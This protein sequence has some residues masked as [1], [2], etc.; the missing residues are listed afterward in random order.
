M[1]DWEWPCIFKSCPLELTIHHIY[2]GR[3]GQMWHICCDTLLYHQPVA[4][5]DSCPSFAP[6]PCCRTTQ[7]CTD[8]PCHCSHCCQVR[9]CHS[10]LHGGPELAEEDRP[11]DRETASEW[12]AVQGCTHRYEKVPAGRYFLAS[13]F[14]Y[15][16]TELQFFCHFFFIE[17]RFQSL[18]NYIP[19]CQQWLA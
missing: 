1:P 4:W 11:W 14:A 13:C 19:Y 3:Q 8:E 7:R 18:L 10:Q 17:A 9:G 2:S 5:G 6:F 12:C 15:I 16:M